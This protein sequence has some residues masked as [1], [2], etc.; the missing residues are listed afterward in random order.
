[1]IPFPSYAR[2]TTHG[3]FIKNGPSVSSSQT[4]LC[5]SFETWEKPDKSA[6]ISGKPKLCLVCGLPVVITAVPQFA[7]TIN[8]HGAGRTIEYKADDLA[9]AV[10]DLLQDDDVLREYRNNAA[11]LAYQCTSEAIFD[12]AFLETLPRIFSSD[13]PP[14]RGEVAF[15]R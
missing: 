12:K 2:R 15:S 13:I 11:T 3:I 1:M 4:A 7:H 14:V 5:P 6:I 8:R 10:I 9:R